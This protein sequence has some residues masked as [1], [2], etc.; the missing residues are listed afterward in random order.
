MAAPGLALDSADGTLQLRGPSP[1][2]SGGG[3]DAQIGSGTS[4]L[5]ALPSDCP[6]LDRSHY[7][8]TELFPAE[9]IAGQAPGW[10]DL[11]YV[12]REEFE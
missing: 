7:M 10:R 6:L 11:L 8:T 4:M 1:S 2:S 3:R 5:G 12:D 9:D